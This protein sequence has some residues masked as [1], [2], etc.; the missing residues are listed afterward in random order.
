M[1]AI[2]TLTRRVQ[3]AETD[4]AGVMHFANYFRWMEEIE[5]AF[6]RSMGLSIM[7]EH[8]GHPIGWPRGRVSCEYFGPVR[9]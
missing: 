6:F 4:L 9:F 7:S 8:D 1:P 3:F 5:H 2:F